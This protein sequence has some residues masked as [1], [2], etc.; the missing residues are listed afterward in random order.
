VIYHEIIPITREEAEIAL[1]SNDPSV[2]CEALLRSAYYDQDWL[3]VQSK[4][5]QFVQHQNKDVRCLAVICL[6]HLAR[7]HGALDTKKVVP[8]LENLRDDPDIAGKVDDV[9]DDIQIFVR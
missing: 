9:L 8:I 4:C 7:I 2:I 3:W 6:G 1:L 5:L